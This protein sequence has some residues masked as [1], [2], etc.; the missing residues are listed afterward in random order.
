MKTRQQ[1]LS[2]GMLREPHPIYGFLTYARWQKYLEVHESIQAKKESVDGYELRA[3]QWVICTR[4]HD[5][6]DLAAAIAADDRSAAFR[7]LWEESLHVSDVVPFSEWWN[8]EVE[9]Y[10]AAATVHKPDNKLGKSE[11]QEEQTPTT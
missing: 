1:I 7:A 5:D 11:K 6:P 9:A 2:A 4:K 10:E 8:S 3:V